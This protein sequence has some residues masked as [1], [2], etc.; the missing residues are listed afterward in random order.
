M[1][2]KPCDQIGQEDLLALI[3]NKVQES[4]S[5]EYKRDL[6]LGNDDEK[7]K[8]LSAITSFAN[9]DGGDLI[10][11]IQADDGVPISIAAMEVQNEDAL[12]LKLETLCQSAIE[13]RLPSIEFQFINVENR[14]VLLIRIPKSWRSPHRLTLGGH[15]HFYGRTSAGKYHM[16]VNELRTAFTSSQ[17]LAAQL[18]QYRQERMMFISN[19][20]TPIGVH[21]GCAMVFHIVPV[22]AFAGGSAIDLTRSKNDLDLFHPLGRNGFQNS[23]VSLQGHTNYANLSGE[24]T[25]AYTHVTSRAQVEAVMVLTESDGKK[26]VFRKDFEEHLPA[27]MDLYF[28]ILKRM[29]IDS[30][31]YLMLSFVGVSDYSLLVPNG[32]GI[33]HQLHACTEPYSIVQLPEIYVTE[34]GKPTQ[35][36][37]RPVFEMV[38]NL[39]GLHR[40]QN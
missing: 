15:G 7:R 27:A 34:P 16:D 11:G 2:D 20:G 33:G 32:N 24:R 28:P 25:N 8:F 17:N 18:Q 31:F 5:I 29:S 9:T 12:R 40:P 30:P 14:K 1:I 19:H 3:D 36:L 23:K 4:R 22:S 35:E 26:I 6:N 10:Y 37:L 39:F 13:P 21:F 38:W